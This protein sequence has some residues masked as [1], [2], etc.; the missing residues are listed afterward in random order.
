MLFREKRQVV[1]C[2]AAGAI[3]G[4]FLLFRYLPLQ[5]RIKAVRQAKAAQSLALAKASTERAQLPVLKEQFLNL[6]RVV[7][8]YEAKIP[9]Q[10]ELGMFLQEIANLMN[11][12]N[13]KD[14]VVQPGGE[15]KTEELC[16]IPVS[17]RCTGKLERIFEFFNSLQ[18]LNRLV[19]IE[20][21]ELTNNGDFSG[22]VGVKAETIV[23]YRS[24]DGQ[25]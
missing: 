10:R 17:M 15:I 21:V 25:V 9:A 11:K 7:G 19:R 22:D 2:V 13:L 5:K 14:Q 20:Q 23:Y 4:G 24:K 12:H 1:I 16:C 3:V 18:L 8:N 6:E